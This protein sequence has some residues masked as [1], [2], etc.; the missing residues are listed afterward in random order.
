[1]N[2]FFETNLYVLSGPTVMTHVAN[3]TFDISRS[4]THLDELRERMN[5]VS[6]THDESFVIYKK[7]QSPSV[8]AD[9]VCVLKKRRHKSF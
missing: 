8:C 6:H 7:R 4:L 9:R 2:K 5:S 1:M 3:F